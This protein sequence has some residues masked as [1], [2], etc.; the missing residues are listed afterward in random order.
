MFGIEAKLNAQIAI[1]IT[2]VQKY[3]DMVGRLSDV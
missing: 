1:L 3:P 2:L